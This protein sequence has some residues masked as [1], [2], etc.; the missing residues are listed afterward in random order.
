M[1]QLRTILTSADNSGAKKMRVIGLPGFSKRHTASIGDVVK[2][3]VLRATP[4][5]QVKKGDK[6]NVLIIRT[7]KEIRRKD[8]SYVRFGDNAGVLINKTGVLLGSRIFGPVPHEIKR[9]GHEQIV[10]LAKE[11]V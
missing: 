10:S 7:R 9:A 11:V 3:S 8:G 4:T 5:G 2:A 6:V 1:I